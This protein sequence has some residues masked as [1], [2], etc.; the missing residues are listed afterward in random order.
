MRVL[1]IF[2]C[3]LIACAPAKSRPQRVFTEHYDDVHFLSFDAASAT[4][5]ADDKGKRCAA[6]GDLLGWRSP[7]NVD[8]WICQH[9]T[10][11]DGQGEAVLELRFSGVIP[12]DGLY[13]LDSF[14]PGVE[15]AGSVVSR[16]S[17]Y[18]DS[19]STAVL[20]L[21]AATPSCSVHWETPIAR[22]VSQGPAV[23]AA[24]FASLQE[25]PPLPLGACKAGEKL[26][27]RV[28]FVGQANRGHIDVDAFG[29][30]GGKENAERMLGFAPLK[31]STAVSQ[32][33]K[34]TE[35][36]GGFCAE[37]TQR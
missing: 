4:S 9:D 30:Q 28:R 24:P 26:A 23:R 7:A 37:A 15:V 33:H 17:W 3:S 14:G 8:G 13:E 35:W 12:K 5:F 18:G 11:Y 32:S 10:V 20:V 21:D 22:A 19:V 36:N 6:S 25:I 16:S 1:A 27:V 2:L 34:C 29:F 31:D